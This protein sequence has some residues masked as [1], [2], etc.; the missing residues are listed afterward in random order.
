MITFKQYLLETISLTSEKGV[1]KQLLNDAIRRVMKFVY[2]EIVREYKYGVI[3]DANIMKKIKE[4]VRFETYHGIQQSLLKHYGKEP[5]S[6]SSLSFDREMNADGDVQHTRIRIH[7]QWLDVIQ[8]QLLDEIELASYDNPFFDQNGEFDENSLKD[9]FLYYQENTKM[10]KAIDKIVDIFVHE[11]VHVGQFRNQ[12]KRLA[13][14]G[15]I[16]YRSYLTKNKK[17]FNKAINQK[18]TEYDM[19]I[20]H[21]SPQEIDAFAHNMAIELVNIATGGLEIE[22]FEHTKH[23]E[24]LEGMLFSV[25]EMLKYREYVFADTYKNRYKD[26]ND[27][28]NKLF[29]KVYKRFMKKVYMEIQQYMSSIKNKIQQ[30][31]NNNDEELWY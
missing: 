22:D 31:K 11:L 16:E 28:K 2:S 12:S 21:G 14:T 10:D 25:E 19:K 26:F 1:V 6:V 29:Y 17:E 13:Y 5:F 8:N 3:T 18:A 30:V 24:Y 7:R 27:P 9:A 23:L 15:S 20:Y 4:Y